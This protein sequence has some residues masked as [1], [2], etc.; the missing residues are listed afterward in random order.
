M[1]VSSVSY[2][3]NLVETRYTLKE[4]EYLPVQN[5]LSRWGLGSGGLHI[6]LLTPWLSTMERLRPR[7][8]VHSMVSSMSNK[9]HLFNAS[10]SLI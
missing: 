9:R 5:P 10:G 4:L 2:K 6:A 1:Y 3:N 8:N 7:H